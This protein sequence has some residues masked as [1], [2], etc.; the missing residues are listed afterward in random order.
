MVTKA[1]PMSRWHDIRQL[2]SLIEAE[3]E[4]QLIDRDKAVALAR[5]LAQHHPQI[6]AS[7]HM[8]VERMEAPAHGEE[9]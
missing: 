9:M 3:S 2:A 5:L 1:F 6:G 7:L 4:G 8:I